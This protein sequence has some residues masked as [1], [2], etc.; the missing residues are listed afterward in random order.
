MHIREP[1]FSKLFKPAVF[2]LALV[3]L[4]LLGWGVWQDTLGANPIET[5]TRSLGEWGLRF[6]L[7]T[8]L[9][10]TLRRVTGWVQVLRL[11]RMLGL[12]AFFYGTLHL[13]S[14]VWL[15]QFFDWEE[16]WLDI[17]DRPFMTVGMLA[18][19]LM[20]PLAATSFQAAIRRLGRNWQRLHRL[21]YPLTLLGVLH[22]WWLADSKV[23]TDMPLVYSVLLA[24][25]LGERLYQ[26]A[27][28]RGQGRV[29]SRAGGSSGIA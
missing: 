24:L 19:V 10:S 8:L 2:A 12:F 3:P 13:L 5:V 29:L 17:L 25:L 15:D 9:V 16:I 23:R 6:L 11:R 27:R 21:V 4:A 26:F 22:F 20:V 7:L 18:F 28:K 1:Y 14:Y